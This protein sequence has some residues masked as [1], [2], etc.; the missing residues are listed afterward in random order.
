MYP[1]PR[2]LA[3][4]KK[5]RHKMVGKNSEVERKIRERGKDGVAPR[6]R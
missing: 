4:L 2:A 6:R 3:V 5:R 1:F